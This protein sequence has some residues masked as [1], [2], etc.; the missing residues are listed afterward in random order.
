MILDISKERMKNIPL[1][2]FKTLMNIIAS[3]GKAST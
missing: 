3:P 2:R 1:R